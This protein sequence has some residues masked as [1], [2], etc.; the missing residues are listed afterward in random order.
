MDMNLLILTLAGSTIM[1]LLAV[2]GYLTRR[3]I[4]GLV[5]SIDTLRTELNDWKTHVSEQLSAVAQAVA[6]IDERTK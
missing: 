3:L 2:I 5:C 1:L 4:L 6:R